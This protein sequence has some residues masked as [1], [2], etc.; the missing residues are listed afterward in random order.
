MNAIYVT[1]AEALAQKQ[2]L[3]KEL[4]S[5]IKGNANE[6]SPTVYTPILYPKGLFEKYTVD[7]AKTYTNYK[8]ASLTPI[9]VTTADLLDNFVFIEVTNGVSKKVTN[10]KPQ[11]ALK[12]TVDSVTTDQAITP[13]GVY[14]FGKNDVQ[15]NQIGI[16]ATPINT[17]FLVGL[18][19]TDRD[20]NSLWIGGYLNNSGAVTARPT[21]D[22]ITNNYFH[23]LPFA[24][25]STNL[26]VS[27]S[28]SSIIIYNND[29]TIQQTFQ[30]KGNNLGATFW[31]FN[32][33][34][35]KG[36][37]IKISYE[38]IRETSGANMMLL[39]DRT[40]IN[41]TDILNTTDEVFVLSSQKNTLVDSVLIDKYGVKSIVANTNFISE[42][43]SSDV[44]N[45][46]LWKRGLIFADGTISNEVNWYHTAKKYKLPKGNYKGEFFF[47]GTAVALITDKN[48]VIKQVLTNM[49]SP[50]YKLHTI[51]LTEDSFIQFSHRESLDNTSPLYNRTP[52]ISIK[53]DADIFPTLK[54]SFDDPEKGTTDLRK[55]YKD[56]FRPKKKRLIAT[57]ISD[58]GDLANPDWYIPILNEKGVKSTFAIVADW[59]GNAY[60]M[61]KTQ[62]RNLY[63][64]GH[65]IASHTKTHRY[66]NTFPIDEVE[67]E[68]SYTKVFLESII[69]APVDMFISPFGVRSPALDNRISKYYKANFIT[70]YGVNN[71]LPLD[72]YFINRVSFDESAN[73]V[74]AL[75][76]L[77]AAIDEA[78][79]NNQWLVFAIHPQYNEYKLSNTVDRRQELRD[80]IDYLK[81]QGFLIMPAKDAYNYYRNPVEIGVKR[82]NDNYYKLSMDGSEE[83]VNYF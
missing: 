17:D 83:N 22:W 82:F 25:Y 52:L 58:D 67:E 60:S 71:V 49:A 54:T 21:R 45:T 62:V 29:K 55:I 59:V 73:N 43:V 56:T 31:T 64:D 38:K 78:V 75:V 69:N 48:D 81:T 28:V 4:I 53:N 50:D 7:V 18:K 20:D 63:L 30:A 12:Q 39:Q 77:K 66:M 44:L 32:Q 46:T 33:T 14:D 65:D 19:G 6:T 57:F 34:D 15:R 8:D 51:V 70:G 76:R 36:G 27:G 24:S 68:L 9:V 3:Q 16:Q 79:V 40:L 1:K 37:F 26:F 10:S 5:G 80:I 2:E 42:L 13:K 11:V 74:S 41:T 61:T 35:K 72:S 23:P 47:R